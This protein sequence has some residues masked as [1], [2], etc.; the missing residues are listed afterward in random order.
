MASVHPLDNVRVVLVEP[1]TPGNIGAVARVLKNTGIRSLALVNPGTWDTSEARWMAHG[2]TDVLD[3]CQVFAD[4]PS[5]VADCHLV[6]GTTH[7]QG[8]LRQL[9]CAPR[10]ALARIASLLNSRRVGLVFG[11]E[12]D[13]LWHSELLLCHQLIRF[14]TA[15]SHPSLNLSHAV[16]LFAYEL[17]AATTP[18]AAAPA[19]S[20]ATAAQRERM[21]RHLEE[22]L[23]AIDFSP[24]NDD[25]RHFNR[26][27]RRFFNKV[28]LD[29]RDVRL[30]HKLCGQIQKFSA[31]HR[32]G[33]G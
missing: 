26:L 18:C 27:L 14:P 17:F 21:Y 5:A 11:R 3:S 2:A 19:V 6:V 8:R 15:V 24:Y 30:I 29:V 12:K 13:G 9:I 20:L 25:P 23:A 31:R 16:L 33:P 1:A 28:E 22:A 4:L 10:P 32:P 7:R